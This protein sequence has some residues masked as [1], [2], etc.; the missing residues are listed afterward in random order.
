MVF[1]SSDDMMLDYLPC[2]YGTSKLLFRGPQR[3][4]TEPYCAILGGTETYG[5]FVA[6][7][8]PAL[9][10]TKIG[11]HVVNLGCPNAGPDVFLNDPA[12]LHVAGGAEVTVVQLLGAQN[13]TNRFYAVH[14]RRNDRFLRAAQPL[15]LLYP[16]VDF[17]EFHFNRH[18]L[19]ALHAVDP[20][21]FE[22]LAD[23]LR[24]AWVARTAEIVRRLPGPVVLLWAAAH[25]PPAPGAR[26]DPLLSPVLVDS[27]MIQALRGLVA[28]YVEVVSSAE[29]RAEGVSGMI[30]TPLYH[31]AAS[32]LPG[33][34][35]H[36]EIARAL[37][38]RL[39][40]L[41]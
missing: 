27:G 20:L 6:D 41:L 31:R 22:Q 1:V 13:L 17:T 21:R 28:D 40:P 10:E 16:E 14:P 5:K 12:I 11:L 34:A 32:E 29:A 38:D 25:A 23:E 4:L 33:P 35:V 26:V 24:I 18:M 30:F 2:H 19:Q 3:P 8:F 9:V 7:P 39:E 37:A 15:R 36:R